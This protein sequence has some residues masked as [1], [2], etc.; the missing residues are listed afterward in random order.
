[1]L[2]RLAPGA[3][4]PPHRHA[5]IEELYL[6]DG[7]LTV[8]DRKLYPGDYIRAEPGTADHRVWSESGCTGVLLTS[9]RDVLG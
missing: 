5:G 7:E 6:L 2:I 8:D 3:A 9:T 4:Y 1:M